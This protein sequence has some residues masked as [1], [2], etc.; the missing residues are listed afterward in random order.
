MAVGPF[1][2]LHFFSGKCQFVTTRKARRTHNLLSPQKL[3]RCLHN[4]SISVALFHWQFVTSRNFS[5]RP[6]RLSSGTVDSEWLSWTATIFFCWIVLFFVGG[7][8]EEKVYF[9]FFDRWLWV[10]I[11]PVWNDVKYLQSAVFKFWA[12]LVS[13][14]E[15]LNSFLTFF[16]DKNTENKTQNLYIFFLISRFE[17][18]VFH[19]QKQNQNLERVE[20]WQTENTDHSC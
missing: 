18:A 6:L 3:N 4:S 20:C 15:R 11:W 9:Y 1:C 14:D 2:G 7:D 8:A 5:S 12:L 13:H 16:E 19:W 10:W 17:P